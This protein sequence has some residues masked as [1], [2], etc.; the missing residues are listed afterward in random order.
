MPEIH[1]TAIVGSSVEIAAG[2]R[3]GPYCVLDGEVSLGEGVQLH[4]H[5][6]LAG[7]TK[8]GTNTQIFPFASIGHRPQDLK[9]DN[10]PSSLEIGAGNI[11]REYVT[12][13]PGTSGG[14]MVTRIGDRCLFMVGAHVAHDCQIGDAVIM[15]N[16]A[17]L[18]GHVTVGDYAVIGGLSAV[19][20]FVRIGHNAM[21][22]GMSGVENDVIPY[23]MAF[24]ER[25]SLQ[26]INIVGLKRSGI[27][28]EHI[29][30]VLQAYETLFFGE[31]NQADRTEKVASCYAGQEQVG[32]ILSF[33]AGPS[34][35][36]LLRPK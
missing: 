25:A 36:A 10:E 30:D 7:R 21:I 28:R 5:V 34:P 19:H 9:Y 14:G 26:G 13:N 24:G 32:D 35:R 15:A 31:G 1:P 18:A 11:I 6:V 4:S 3:I 16:N 20:Q 27:A 17:T 29:R 2:C 22:G 23:G 8:V 33:M 12:M